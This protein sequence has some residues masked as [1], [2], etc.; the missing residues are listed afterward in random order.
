VEIFWRLTSAGTAGGR[1]ERLK[2]FGQGF[3]DARTQL[4]I[5]E[6]AYA[7]DLNQAGRFELLYV[8]R[9]GGGRDFQCGLGLRTG[10]RTIGFGYAL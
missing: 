1:I 4:E 7:F 3:E 10:Q 5:V 9:E 8:V 2:A 6:L